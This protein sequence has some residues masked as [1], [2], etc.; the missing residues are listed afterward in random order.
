MTSHWTAWRHV[1]KLDPARAL[2]DRTLEGVARSGTDA[3]VLGG[4]D[5]LTGEKVETLLERVR[6]HPWPVGI[7]V[8]HPACLAPGADWYFIPVVLNAGDPEWLSAAH[9]RTLAE[10]VRAGVALDFSRV[11]GEGYVVQNPDSAVGHMT[12]ALPVASAPEAAAAALYARYVLGLPLVY[13]EYSG[14]FG[15]PALVRAASGALA[16]GIRQA[17]PPPG[18]GSPR[19]R[20]WYGGG[21]DGAA[22]AAAVAAV[23]DTVVVGNAV[24]TGGAAVLAETVR[25]VRE[26]PGPG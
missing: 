7:E 10:L 26:T 14:A 1:T 22:R 12:R 20:V 2:D 18:T 19:P 17:G 11:V 8:S 3:V 25:G 15:G 21:V 16:A 6:R 9:R 4:T 23:A 5:G 13:F 24:Y